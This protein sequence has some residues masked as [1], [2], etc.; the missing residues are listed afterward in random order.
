M[1]EARAI[2]VRS[3]LYE[4][5]K[6]MGRVSARAKTSDGSGNESSR[7]LFRTFWVRKI[8]PSHA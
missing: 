6:E 5:E 7:N 2:N 4:R 8:D 1:F 3:T